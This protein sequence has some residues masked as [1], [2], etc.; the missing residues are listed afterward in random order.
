MKLSLALT[1]LFISVFAEAAELKRSPPCA[2]PAPQDD[3]ISK[4]KEFKA[5]EKD[6]AHIS[7]IAAD[8]QINTYIHIIAKDR[9]YDGGYVSVRTPCLCSSAPHEP[10]RIK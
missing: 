7:S 9:T 8:R 2:A 5:E 6:Q 3:F 1:T 4:M 10:S